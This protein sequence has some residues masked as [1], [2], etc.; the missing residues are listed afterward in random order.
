[1]TK[2][3]RWF[4]PRAA[5][6]FFASALLCL[7]ATTGSTEDWPHFLGPRNNGTST[8]TGLLNSFPKEGPQKIWVRDIGT[9]YAAPSVRAGRLVLHHR[10]GNEEIVEAINAETGKTVWTHKYPSRY[11]DPFGYNNG[12]RC[13]PLLTADY[14]YTYGA[15]GQLF[16]LN[17][18]TGKPVWHRDTAK[19]WNVPVAFFGVGST[20]I[21]E[22]NKLII[23]IGGQPNSGMVA[24]EAKTG[25][26]IWE[27]VGK[28]NWEGVTTFGWRAEIPYNWTG[29]EK[30][31]SYASPVAA[32]IHGKRQ[33]ICF[34]RQGLCSVDPV[35]GKIGFSRWFQ[36]LVGDSVNAMNPVVQDDLVLISAAYFRSGAMLLRVNPDGKSFQEV[37]KEPKRHPMDAA[38]RD[39]Q[40][41]EW[42]I[43]V[44]EIHWM[45][46][47]LHQGHI[48]AFSGRNEP[49]ASFRCVEF[50]T[51]RLKWTRDESWRKYGTKQPNVFG[52]GSLIHADNKLIALGEG[53][54]LGMFSLNSEKPT[55]LARWQVPEMHHPCWAGPVLS[56]KKLYLRSE[57]KLVCLD[58][59]K[60]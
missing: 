19:D 32:T 48:Y 11:V 23:M 12:P 44:L 45:T 41:G 40:T 53:G 8:E 15:E 49:D 36:S 51:G 35:T 60:R 16:C 54:L 52:R 20:P 56:E 33:L 10:R 58:F 4:K 38:D 2:R 3:D 9:G 42:K 39:P 14:C 6:Q 57:D 24:L 21:L 46:P 55:E 43:P 34:M 29:H 5:I 28:S 18:K 59:A 13:S 50:K 31:A 47:I 7:D 1:M 37:W 30:L 26:T 27:S 22:G 25:K 17:I